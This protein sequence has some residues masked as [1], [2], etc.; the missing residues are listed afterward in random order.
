MA[1]DIKADPEMLE[2]QPDLDAIK[3]DNDQVGYN[4][5]KAAQEAGYEPVS[6]SPLYYEMKLISID[7]GRVQAST[8]SNRPF[9]PSH[10]H[11]YSVPSIHG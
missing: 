10:L 1:S 7:T 9:H 6:S 4:T 11:L 2:Y 3:E 8:S 5:F